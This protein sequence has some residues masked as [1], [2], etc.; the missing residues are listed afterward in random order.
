MLFVMQEKDEAAS[1]YLRRAV[2][3]DPSQFK[4]RMHLAWLYQSRRTLPECEDQLTQ[5][6]ALRPAD[7]SPP[8]LLAD[9]YQMMGRT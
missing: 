7:R 3:L 8:R 1:T 4:L 5:S 9:L 2:E 6:I